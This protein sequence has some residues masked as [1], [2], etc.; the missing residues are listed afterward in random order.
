MVA[1]VKWARAVST[2]SLAEAREK[3]REARKLL[4]D[5]IDPIEARKS[6]RML[7]RLEAARGMTFAQCAEKYIAAH[8][9]SWRN[10]KHREQW[11]ATLASYA[12]PVLGDLSVAAIDTTLVLKVIE[13]IWHVK[14][15][16]AGRLRGRIER[17][18]DWAKARGYRNGENPALWTGHL[19]KLLPARSKVRAIKH[20]PAL[21]YSEMPKFMAELRARDTTP[22]ARALEFTILT[23]ARTGATI[24]AQWNEI[25][26]AARVWTVPAQR[27]GA[28]T[29]NRAGCLLVTAYSKFSGQFHANL[30]IR[31]SSS[32]AALV[33]ASVMRRCPNF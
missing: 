10:A 27:V 25:D 22:Q 19:D 3:A 9:A 2:L 16:T 4:L 5:G 33:R 30:T 26:L 28:K 1:S 32:A 29:I 14:P 6:Q 20:H 31:S 7:A 24:L 23:V 18:L 21:P 8:E 11:T 13:P 12:Y 15:E 17:V